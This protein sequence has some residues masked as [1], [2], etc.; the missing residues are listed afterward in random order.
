LSNELSVVPHLLLEI[1]FWLVAA[2]WLRGALLMIREVGDL[3]VLP[4]HDSS[5]PRRRVSVVVAARDE[6]EV[7][8]ATVR[9][10]LAQSNVELEVIVAS[11]RST[12]ATVAILERLAKEDSRVRAVVI[13]ELP[14]GWLGKCFALD[15]AAAKATGEW[16]LFTDADVRLE[17][18]AIVRAVQHADQQQVE[19]VTAWFNSHESTLL[20]SACW[21]TMIL[22]GMPDH[23]GGVNRD[24]PGSFA[25]TGAFN[26]VKTAAY[27]DAGG[28]TALR[29]TVFE[30]VKL[31]LLLR[32]AGFRT[33]V[34]LGGTWVTADWCVSVGRL[35][36]LLE[37]NSYSFF[38]Y[39]LS[40]F[41]PLIV[42]ILCCW[43]LSLVGPFTGTVGGV[44]ALVALLS[45]LIP[46]VIYV[47]R[48]QLPLG[49][50]FL[51]P[52]VWPIAPVIFANSAWTTHRQGGVRW[53]DTFYPL[54]QL[55]DGDI[56]AVLARQSKQ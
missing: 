10:I 35:I 17:L 37:K 54:E 18:N 5:T 27:R 16:L 43:V 53:R 50:A 44:A 26:L 40:T 34:L 14:D 52:F 4:P 20:G 1:L 39:R 33:R 24:R 21:I 36:K 28:H 11:D 23:L 12:D 45:T 48:S 15:Q 32:S 56:A 6:A 42:C 29:L 9:G 55:R 41:V 49:P 38:N 46:A 22:G 13:D 2:F 47:R 3:Q 51:V 7:I 31:G 8:E 19:H 25:G 30:D